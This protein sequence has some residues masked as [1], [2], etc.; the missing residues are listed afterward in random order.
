VRR[1]GGMKWRLRWKC[2]PTRIGAIGKEYFD[3]KV[4]E[5]DEI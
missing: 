3:E 4:R 2:N 1:Y 5:N